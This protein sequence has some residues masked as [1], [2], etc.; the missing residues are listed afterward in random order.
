MKNQKIPLAALAFAFLWLFIALFP[1]TREILRAFP[2]SIGVFG[3]SIVGLEN[4]RFDELAR[5]SPADPLLLAWKQEREFYDVAHGN[6][7]KALGEMDDLSA[8][9]PADLSLPAQRLRASLLHPVTIPT[10]EDAAPRRAPSKNQWPGDADWELAARIAQKSAAREPDNAFWPW[11]SAVFHFARRQNRAGIADLER[12]AGCSRFDDYSRSTLKAR[13]RWFEKTAHPIWEQKIALFF[14]APFPP[15]APLQKTILAATLDAN[16]ARKRGDSAGAARIGAAILGACAVWHRSDNDLIIRVSQNAARRALE[17]LFGIRAPAEVHLPNG[18][19]LYTDPK[20]HDADLVRAWRNFARQNG[21][22]QWIQRADFLLPSAK[23]DPA[24]QFL[25]SDLWQ[26]FGLPKPWGHIAVTA[27][28]ILTILAALCWIG[29]SVGLI[30]AAIPRFAARDG[31]KMV[32]KATP[33]RGEVTACANFSFWAFA[34][35][36]TVF[37]RSFASNSIF[38][39]FQHGENGGWMVDGAFWLTTIIGIWALPIAFAGW[40]RGHRIVRR[41][42]LQ[43]AK[44]GAAKNDAAQEKTLK[45]ARKMRGARAISWGI[46]GLCTFAAWTNGGSYGYGIWDDTPLQMPYSLILAGAS[47]LVAL[48]LEIARLRRA[49]RRFGP[50]FQVEKIGAAPP[51]ET[52]PARIARIGLWLLCPALLFVALGGAAWNATRTDIFLVLALAAMVFGGAFWL[53]SKG[54]RRDR[55]FF[56]LQLGTRSA[57]V[58]SL[59]WSVVFLG[60]CLGLWPLRVELNHQLD[61]RL[62]IG[63]TNWMREQ[64]AASPQTAP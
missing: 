56:A 37:L 4:A 40:K 42:P 44:K 30:G 33:T 17:K 58:L 36:L 39:V 54:A 47:G 32:S 27:P 26:E 50:N 10:A 15:H 59:A 11:M 22:A 8:R 60:L 28:L 20:I 52:L 24:T 62:Q 57:G 29:A 31:E 48:S 19:W 61:R 5:Q 63:E 49:G 13:I 64:V 16:R 23:E 21:G 9:F 14:S 53:E 51:K 12:A 45:N 34:G 38:S 6:I 2:A 55:F 43:P 3:S 41:A 18:S 35:L 25:H 1:P 7:R 46:F